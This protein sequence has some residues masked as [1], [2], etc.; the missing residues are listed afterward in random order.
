MPA[1][2]PRPHR[3][4]LADF[5]PV[6]LGVDQVETMLGVVLKLAANEGV[7]VEIKAALLQGG[8]IFLGSPPGRA[9]ILAAMRAG[10]PHSSRRRETRY[11]A[12]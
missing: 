7:R 5:D 8:L 12:A 10:S 2:C 3:R 4:A 1:A 6:S 11:T 9:A